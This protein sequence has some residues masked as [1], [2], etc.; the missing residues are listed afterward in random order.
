MTKNNHRTHKKG[1]HT[2]AKFR[3]DHLAPK[4][5]NQTADD[6]LPIVMIRNPFTWMSSM[7]RIP[8]SAFW[9]RSDPGTNGKDVCPHLAYADGRRHA[10]NTGGTTR[11]S[12]V[13]LEYKFSG[14][15]LSYDSLAHLWN[16]WYAGYWRDADFPFLMVRLEDL[17]FRQYE[18]TR[19][20]CDC[21]GG[22][23]PSADD[24]RYIV[25][26]AKTGPAHGKVSERTDMIDAWAK[27]GKPMLVKAGFSDLDYHAAVEY[28]SRELMGMMD[29]KYPPSE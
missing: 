12:P 18:A 20:I 7:C 24:F 8:Y 3:H 17:I 10:T 15:A 9:E 13:G 22:T 2:P 14:H 1:K 11:T 19:L 26:S 29:Y 6:C 4:N 25:H 27:Y 28:L 21:A 5:E 23:I 16:D